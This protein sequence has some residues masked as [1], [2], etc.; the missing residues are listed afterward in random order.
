M[1]RSSADGSEE[2]GYIPVS[3]QASL[4]Y[5]FFKTS[6]PDGHLSRPIVLWLEGGPGL[7][8]AGIANFLMIGPLN[9]NMTA[10]EFTW[11]QS[12]N[13]LFVDYPG[14][15]GFSII[16]DM[17]FLAPNSTVIGEELVEMLKVFFQEHQFYRRNPFFIFGESYGGKM[18]PVVAWLLNKA[19]DEGEI[20]CNLRGASIGN[21]WVSGSDIMVHWP[22]MLYQASLIDNI[23][24][25]NLTIAAWNGVTAAYLEDWN[26]FYEEYQKMLGTVLEKLPFLNFYDVQKPYDVPIAENDF[27]RVPAQTVFDIP[28]G[29]FMNGPVKQKLGIIPQDKMYKFNDFTLSIFYTDNRDLFRPVIHLVDDL[30]MKSDID[31]IIY[32][33][34]N[35]IICCTPGVLRWMSR[36]TWPQK[37]YWD[38][39][40]RRTLTVPGT[41]KVEM[42]VKSHQKL[43]MYWLPGAGHVVPADVPGA[44][45]RMLN[46]ILDDVD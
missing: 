27:I 16:D 5:W 6:H 19:L 10:R 21:G 14:G 41:N 23:Q 36:L 37:Q 25:V 17:S 28:I 24:K 12:T 22:E 1:R 34:T 29:D 44:A 32:Q 9:Q 40:E 15:T 33:G 39:A 8:A 7:S 30:L 13:I 3:P 42:F 18:T 45:F 35:D 2:W 11:V 31:I 26:W 38:A 20:E 4:F 43:K 46:R